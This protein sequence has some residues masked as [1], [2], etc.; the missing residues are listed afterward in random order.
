VSLEERLARLYAEL[1]RLGLPCLV[2]DAHA[3]RYHAVDR[4]TVD[5]D[6]HL[7]L[8]PE[9][10][11][12]L[13]DVL[14]RSPPLATAREDQAGVPATSVG[15]SLAGLRTVATRCSGASAPLRLSLCGG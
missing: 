7:A 1:L 8:E 15:S 3:V 13:A 6:F 5:F 14:R 10:W 11:T 12:K 2:M 4:S 9:A